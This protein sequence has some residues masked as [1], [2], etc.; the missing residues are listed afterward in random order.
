MII[1]NPCLSESII[2]NSTLVVLFHSFKSTGTCPTKL[3]L[4][5]SLHLPLS[6]LGSRAGAAR[7]P[8]LSWTL[9]LAY[10]CCMYTQHRQTLIKRLSLHGFTHRSAFIFCLLQ[11]GFILRSRVAE[12]RYDWKYMTE[13]IPRLL[14]II[15]K[16][17]PLWEPWNHEARVLD[18]E[19]MG[20]DSYVLGKGVG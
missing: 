20:V 15:F 8:C 4:S 7:P 3:A 13:P 5:L 11:T 10:H 2:F 9:P 17:N 16:Q 6:L 1:L 14:Y 19:W 18:S 12:P